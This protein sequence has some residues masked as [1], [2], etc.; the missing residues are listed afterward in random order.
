MCWRAICSANG[1]TALVNLN[2]LACYMAILT[3]R[4]YETLF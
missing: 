4:P 1:M 3:I 2:L